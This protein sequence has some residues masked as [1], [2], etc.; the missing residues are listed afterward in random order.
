MPDYLTNREANMKATRKGVLPNGTD[1]RCVRRCLA[2]S[3]YS[4]PV[5]PYTR[6]GHVS[7]GVMPCGCL[8]ICTLELVWHPVN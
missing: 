6:P 4:R 7:E 5:A 1:V 2:V 8:T 3:G